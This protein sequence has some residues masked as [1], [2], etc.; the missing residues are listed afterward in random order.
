MF[1]AMAPTPRAPA[2]LRAGIENHVERHALE[3]PGASPAN[4]AVALALINGFWFMRKV[5]GSTALNETDEA[6]LAETLERLFGCCCP[7]VARP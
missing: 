3:V 5:I 2:I 6:T 7:N 4:A 1:L